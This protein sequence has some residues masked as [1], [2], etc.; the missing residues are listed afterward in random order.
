MA[1]RVPVGELLVLVLLLLAPKTK[2][3][4]ITGGHNKSRGKESSGSS[5]EGGAISFCLSWR[6]AVEANNVVAWPTVPPQCSRYVETYMINGQYDRDL[7][8]I[9]EVILAYVNQTFLLGDA[10]DAWIL[11]VDDTC[12]SNIYYYKGKKYGCDP[13]DPFSFRTWAMKGGCPAIPSVLR[14]FNIL[15]DK[16]FKVFL[17]TGRDEETLGQVTRNNLHNQGFI[18][19][20]RLILR[21]S[22]YKGKS[23]MKYKSDVRK[24]LED[25]GYRIWGNVGDQWSDIQGDYLGN[26]TFKLPNPIRH[27][28]VFGINNL[29]LGA[30]TKFIQYDER[31]ISIRE[32]GSAGALRNIVRSLSVASSRALLPRISTNASMAP[33]CFALPSPCKPP[34]RLLPLWSHFHSLT[35]T[36]FP[37]RRPS[38]RPRRK[39]ASLRPSGPYA[40]VQYTPGQPILPNKP[41]EGSVKRRNEKKRMRQRRAFILAERKKRKAQLQEA[42]RKKNI[43][44]VERKMAAVARER[45]WAERL[46]ELQ[47][48]EEEKKK[49]MA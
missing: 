16:G 31:D 29:L 2:A 20:E 34:Q 7:D 39:R 21:S 46:A 41:N 8:L 48:L 6:L 30:A 40:W 23:A 12:I 47:R 26:R 43:Q 17:L 33:I 15:V 38:E 36:R 3:M 25:Q 4:S 28:N 37:K 22:A 14:L 19:Y 44:R 32:M 35:D 5:D 1:K 27:A 13:Y 24:Q 45:D 49:S 42:N 18:G 10:M 9:V 11:D